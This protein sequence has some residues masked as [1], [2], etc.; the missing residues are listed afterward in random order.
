LTLQTDKIG[1][2]VPN[3]HVS[4]E[5]SLAD[6]RYIVFRVGDLEVTRPTYHQPTRTNRKS[7]QEGVKVN[8][9]GWCKELHTWCRM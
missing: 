4:D 1:S 7:Y 9:G 2:P 8:L 3:W 6:H 5:I